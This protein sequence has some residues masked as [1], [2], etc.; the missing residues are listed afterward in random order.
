MTIIFCCWLVNNYTLGTVYCLDIGN[1]YTTYI[2][3]IGQSRNKCKEEQIIY[4]STVEALYKSFACRVYNI[5]E[6]LRY[7]NLIF[8]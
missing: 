2:W 5:F 6:K 8:N 4:A 1:Y 7:S 3:E